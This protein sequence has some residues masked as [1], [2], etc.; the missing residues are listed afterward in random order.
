MSRLTFNPGLPAILI[1]ILV[2]AGMSFLSWMAWRRSVT[3]RR[4]FV[5]LESLRWILTL[6][7]VITLWKPEWVTIEQ[8]TSQPEIVILSDRSRSMETEDVVAEGGASVES[9][10]AWLA[11]QEAA[12]FWSSLQDRYS[13]E[14]RDF[15]APSDPSDTD[16]D[17]AAAV[18]LEGTDINSAL[19]DALRSH[20]NLRAVL[21]LSDGDHNLGESPM[22]S[23]TRLRLRQIPVY[24]IAAGSSRTLPDLELPTVS[25]PTYGIIGEPMLIPFTIRSSLT[26]DVE[27][28]VRLTT[29]AGE[30]LTKQVVLPAMRETQEGIFWT[31]ATEGT[32]AL[33]LEV[34]LQPD[35]LRRDNNRQEFQISARRESLRVLVVESLPRWEYRYLRN[36]LSRDPGVEVSCLLFHPGLGPGDGVDYIHSFPDSIDQLSEFD[37]VFLGDVGIGPGELTEEDCN[38]L[39]GLVEQ[40]ASGLVFLPGPRGRQFT[41]LDTALAELMPVLLDD[42]NLKGSGA[43]APSALV[44]TNLGKG[45]LLTLLADSEGENPGVWRD[46]PGFYW[47]APVLKSKAGSEVLAVHESLRNQFGRIPLLVTRPAGNGKVLFMGIDGA[48]RWRRGVEDKYHYRFWGQVARWMSYQRHMSE[49]ERVRLIYS[50]D[51]PRSGQAITLTAT[52]MDAAGSPVQGGNVRAEITGPNGNREIVSLNPGES[53]WGVFFSRFTAQSPGTYQVRIEAPGAGAV[54]ETEILVQGEAREQIGRPARRDLLQ[55]VADY[56]GGRLGTTADLVGFV[57]SIQALPSPEPVIRTVRL[58]AHPAWAGLL[59]FLFTVFWTGRKLAGV[60]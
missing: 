40:Q 58:W 8:P 16:P 49:G 15:S 60:I 47:H 59:I 25:A 30:S 17:N 39:R 46:L 45:N 48:W 19:D 7:A 5:W 14:R 11:K 10:A 36:A 26:R 22:Q 38:R 1:G 41:L 57:A 37:V 24:A 21:L 50:P 2:L 55:E 4:S 12:E 42:A 27:V 53:G 35:E 18:L 20:R 29:D 54:H 23:A 51:R 33:S 32:V 28:A 43:P 9:R 31:P 13:V 56:T 52:V 3:R 6:L 34:P 44:L